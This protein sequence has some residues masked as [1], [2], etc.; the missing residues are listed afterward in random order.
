[1]RTKVTKHAQQTS[2]IY[3]IYKY[4]YRA[5]LLICT[6]IFTCPLYGIE[7]I[8]RYRDT[9]YVY[10]T[11]YT[12]MYVFAQSAFIYMYMCVSLQKTKTIVCFT[13]LLL[14]LHTRIPLDKKN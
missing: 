6:C 8:I 4:N 3:Y 1:M 13:T 5:Q 10:Y 9:Y 11:V 2:V 14:V 12:T 7:N